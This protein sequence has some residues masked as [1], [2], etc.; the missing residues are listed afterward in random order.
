MREQN[1]LPAQRALLLFHVTQMPLSPS[2]YQKQILFSGMGEVGQ[3]RL[4]SAHAVLVGCGALGSVIA[5]TLVRAGIGT[6]TLI[7]RDFVELSNL[8]RQVL[9]DED[10][11]AQRLPKAIA[12]ER[13]LHR[14]NGE[15]TLNAHV[16]DVTCHNIT[17]LVSGADVILDGTDNF[18]IRFLINDV[19]VETGIPWVHGG[20]VGSHGQVMAIVPGQTP[21]LRC[22]MPEIPG[23]GT[24]ETCDSAGVISPAVQVVASLQS[25]AAL[26]ILTGQRELIRPEMIALDVWSGSFRQVKLDSLVQ[27]RQC[28]CCAQGERLWLSG[29][30]GAQ[31]TVLCGRNSVQIS[32]SE[33]MTMKLPQLQDRLSELGEARTNP[34][35]LMFR[36]SHS[37][38][39]LTIFSD[40]R[41]IITG[42]EDLVQARALYTQYIGL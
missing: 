19:S 7:D 2:R 28:P 38:Y 35:L 27:D 25:A 41:A 16:C 14:I 26:K 18:E 8:Q 12:A 37:E 22:V 30:A 6:L 39:E 5:E 31:A 10:D 42:T 20:C 9:Y 23:P 13:K 36:P 34:F 1:C 33:R 40:G 29:Q 15:V 32:P 17:E 11:V 21:C 4:R 24:T 3:Q